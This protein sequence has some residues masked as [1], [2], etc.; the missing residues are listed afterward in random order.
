M[1]GTV[2]ISRTSVA[3]GVLVFEVAKGCTT[4]VRL[5]GFRTQHTPRP[6]T[7]TNIIEELQ[8]LRD[9]EYMKFCGPKCQD[10]CDIDLKTSVYRLVPRINTPEIVTIAPPSFDGIVAPPIQVALDRPNSPLRIE[11]TTR[12]I[13]YLSKVCRYQVTTGHVVS[14]QQRAE[15][16]AAGVS[17]MYTEA[18]K[19]CSRVRHKSGTKQKVLTKVFSKEKHH[20]AGKTPDNAFV[21]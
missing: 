12:S 15:V 9:A 19:G 1:N 4:L 8:K 13:E 14:Q 11:L 3:G 20:N 2:L 18:E 7:N 17:S 10:D 6:L 5:F 21:E 16:P